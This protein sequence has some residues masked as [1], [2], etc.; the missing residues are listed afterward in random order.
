LA[1]ERLVEANVNVPLCVQ[2]FVGALEEAFGVDESSVPAG[3]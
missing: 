1:A 2:Q 3:R